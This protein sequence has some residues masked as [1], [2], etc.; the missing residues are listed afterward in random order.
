MGK[1]KKR[2][3]MNLIEWI[4]FMIGVG[5]LF[6]PYLIMDLFDIVNETTEYERRCYKC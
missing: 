3:E 1:D 4:V 2:K 6:I 5:L